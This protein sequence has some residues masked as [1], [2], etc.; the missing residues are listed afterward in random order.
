MRVAEYS[1]TLSPRFSQPLGKA[2]RVGGG[3]VCAPCG[4]RERVL[5]G[6]SHSLPAFL[7][8]LL[9][10]WL[11]TAARDRASSSQLQKG[12]GL[13]QEGRTLIPGK[14]P[15][16]TRGCQGCGVPPSWG[17]AAGFTHGP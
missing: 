11:L 4:R 1:L 14:W 15:T 13:I 17:S 9:S 10:S 2:R 6:G 8:D 12:P 7:P 3:G 16:C 5:R